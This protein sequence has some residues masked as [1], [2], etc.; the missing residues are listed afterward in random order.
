MSKHCVSEAIYPPHVCLGSH[1]EFI[2]VVD[3]VSGAEIIKMGAAYLTSTVTLRIISKRVGFFVEEFPEG[4]NGRKEAK[5]KA[6]DS[7][8]RWKGMFL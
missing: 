5:D 8:V 4:P 1:Y 7:K 3:T 6:D 2:S